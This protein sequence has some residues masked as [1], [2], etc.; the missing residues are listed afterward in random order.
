MTDRAIVLDK[1]NELM[2]QADTLNGMFKLAQKVAQSGL[3]GYNATPEKVMTIALTGRELGLPF[4]AAVRGIHVIEGKPSPSAAL[5]AALIYDA[6]GDNALRVVESTAEQ[7]TVHYRRKGW[8][9]GDT[10]QLTITMKEARNAEWDM[11]F[12]KR[13]NQMK[14]KDTWAKFPK[15]MLRSRA[16]TMVGQDAFP[17]VVLGLYSPDELDSEHIHMEDVTVNTETGEIPDGDIRDS[18]TRLREPEDVGV[19]DMGNVSQPSGT[20][21]PSARRGNNN[22]QPAPMV[23]EADEI[24]GEFTE[25]EPLTEA[26]QRKI[27]SLAKDMDMDAAALSEQISDF[28]DGEVSSVGSLSKQQAIR[29]IEHFIGYKKE[30]FGENKEPADLPGDGPEFFTLVRDLSNLM[31][32]MGKEPLPDKTADLHN[33]PLLKDKGPK[34]RVNELKR[35]LHSNLLQHIVDVGYDEDK[36]EAIKDVWGKHAVWTETVNEKWSGA[37]ATSQEVAV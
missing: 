4:M 1:P 24:E 31:D 10:E 19:S 17:D 28:F 32:S 11:Y 30:W 27:L 33:I 29:F 14:R 23:A 34:Q 37:M 21:S 26:Q 22:S 5:V 7:C 18:G 13:T 15:A 12:D 25:V 36:L 20:V 2:P 9:D 6:H 16:I 8:P 3:A 35:A